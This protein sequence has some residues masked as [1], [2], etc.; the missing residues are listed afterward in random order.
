[1][2]LTKGQLNCLLNSA[3]TFH[4]PNCGIEQKDACNK[5]EDCLL[6]DWI[7]EKLKEVNH[8]SKTTPK[9]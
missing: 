2:K 4:C 1:M 8:E 5:I 6:I 7:T 3:W 9:V